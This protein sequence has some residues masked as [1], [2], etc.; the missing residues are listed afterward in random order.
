MQTFKDCKVIYNYPHFGLK[1]YDDLEHFKGP[2]VGEKAPD[3]EATDLSG[4]R[5]HLSD[6][7]GKIIVFESGSITCPAT[8]GTTKSMQELVD[9]YPDVTVLLLYVREA[10]PGERIRPHSSFEDKLACAVRFKNEEHDNRVLLVDELEGTIHKQFGL[11]PNFVYVIDQD[12]YVAFR[13]PWNVPDI[14]DEVLTDIQE[15]KK[16]RFPERYYLPPYKNVGLRALPRAGW[17]AILDVIIS[18]PQ[19]LWTRYQLS[20]L[21]KDK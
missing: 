19:G 17:C 11:F 20:K 7:Q 2:K 3:F 18:I 1:E 9:K 12:G 4:K 6:F 21:S 15:G 8:I 10:H 13:T 16:V 5:I 14:L